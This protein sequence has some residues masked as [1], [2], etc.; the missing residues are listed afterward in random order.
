MS[1]DEVGRAFEMSSVEVQVAA[2]EGCGGDFEDCVGGLLDL[3]VRAVFDGDLETTVS[4]CFLI[5]GSK[6]RFLALKS[7]LSTTAR[8]VSGGVKP[9]AV[10]LSSCALSSC[11]LLSVYKDVADQVLLEEVPFSNVW[12]S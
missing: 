9:M 12:S 8:I 7:L 6:L 11:A 1:T 3:W 10:V 2:A 4:T 5:N